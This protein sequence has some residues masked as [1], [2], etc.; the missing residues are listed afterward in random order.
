MD[1]YILTQIFIAFGIWFAS[2][3]VLLLVQSIQVSIQRK[4]SLEK[5][6]IYLTAFLLIR[7]AALSF[8]QI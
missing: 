4:Q 2:S 3:V 5:A 7:L 6:F 8:I 1:D